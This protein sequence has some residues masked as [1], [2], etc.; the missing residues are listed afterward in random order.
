MKLSREK[1]Q[2]RPGLE[3]TQFP[4]SQCSYTNFDLFLVI[5]VNIHPKE[6]TNNDGCAC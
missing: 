5:D 2:V 6:T 3:D 4:L 1:A